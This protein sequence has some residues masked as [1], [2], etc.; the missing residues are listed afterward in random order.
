MTK[1][2][3]PPPAARGSLVALCFSTLLASLGVSIPNVALPTL[4]RVFD[5]PI[6]SVQW[7]VIAYLLSLTVC[8]VG[9]GRVGDLIGRRRVLVAGLGLFTMASALCALATSLEVLVAAR[10][11]QGAAAAGLVALTLALVREAVPTESTG[12]VMGMLGATSAIGTMLGPALGGFLISVAGWSAIFWFL[13]PVGI[14]NLV[15]VRRFL[16]VPTL[17]RVP[18]DSFPFDYSG[19]VLLGVALASYALAVTLVDGAFDHSNAALLLGAAGAGALFLANEGRVGAPLI[20]LSQLRHG[21]LAGSLALNALVS[22]VLMSTLVVGPF[23]L[24]RA[25]GLSESH[26]GMVMAVGPA[27]SALSGLPAG[28]AVDAFGASTTTTAGLLG[29]AAGALGLALL[30]QTFGVIG[31]IAALALLTPGYQL[32]QA[33]NNTAVMTGSYEDHGVISGVLNLSRNLGLITGASL[34]GTVFSLAT[35]TAEVMTASPSA[36]AGGM[37]RTFLV[38]SGSVAVAAAW[39]LSRPDGR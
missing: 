38:A 6:H 8:V 11:I 35:G 7:V 32:F 12:R 17:V 20:R 30:P 23:F 22:T 37:Q 15:L 3:H 14:T 4:A 18:A 28:R 26:V 34:M 36:V 39:R 25:L 33:A 24:S 9:V 1:P 31:Y 5:A 19:T 27:V 2:H 21:G 10:A 29:I 13:V 16:P